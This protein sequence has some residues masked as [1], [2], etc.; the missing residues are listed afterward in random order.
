[1]CRHVDDYAVDSG[2][3]VEEGRNRATPFDCYDM[4][5]RDTMNVYSGILTSWHFLCSIGGS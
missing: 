2:E 1:M 4:I 5:E 3:H